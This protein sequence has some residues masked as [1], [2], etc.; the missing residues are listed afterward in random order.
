MFGL[1]SVILLEAPLLV[2]D[3]CGEIEYPGDMMN[4]VERALAFHMLGLADL[5]PQAVRFL[6]K[7]LGLTQPE[8]AEKL[9]CSRPTIARWEQ[10][11]GDGISGVDSAALRA[12][13]ASL[14]FSDDPRAA[15]IL[16][17]LMPARR[18]PEPRK[19]ELP[20]GSAAFA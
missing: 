14:R 11:E 7:F 20:M 16:R 3:K 6:R 17:S 2:C 1:A 15:E 19:Y 8:L 18:S 12:L 13:V 9:G 10:E 4:A 5:E